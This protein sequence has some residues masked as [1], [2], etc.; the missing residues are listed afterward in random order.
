MM[1]RTA[2]KAFTV[3]NELIPQTKIVYESINQHKYSRLANASYYFKRQSFV[4][5]FLN[6]MRE[7]RQ[8]KLDPALSN[9]EVSTFVNRITREVV[10]AYRGTTNIKDVGTDLMILTSTERLSFRVRSSLKLMEQVLRKYTDFKVVSTGHS[11]GSFLSR[12][13]ANTFN[14]ESHNFNSAESI[15]GSF[16]PQNAMTFNYRT[17]YDA[18]SILSKNSI[19]VPTKIG[20]EGTIESVH[21]LNNFYNKR[22]NRVIVDGEEMLQSEKSTKIYEH[23]A[24]LGTALNVAIVGY[25]IQ[26]G[27]KNKER[28]LNIADTITRDILPPNPIQL[29][30]DSETGQF[31]QGVIKDFVNERHEHHSKSFMQELHDIA[32]NFNQKTT[33][34]TGYTEHSVDVSN[35]REVMG[36]NISG[37]ERINPHRQNRFKP[38]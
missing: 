16:I 15:H 20:N 25:D 5:D 28:P 23:S 21:R 12:I 19:R 38:E 32:S 33:T 31:I 22:A 34:D 35:Y 37:I 2:T 17:H 29:A 18:V 26:Q 10:V 11:M 8:F 30:E 24:H 36:Q 7:T 4:K 27:V 9:D 6:E 13:V 3:A 14:L 1:L